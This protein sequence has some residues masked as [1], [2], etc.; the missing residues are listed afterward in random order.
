MEKQLWEMTLKQYREYQINSNDEETI[1]N[2][3]EL[4]KEDNRYYNDDWYYQ[5]WITVLENAAYD[6]HV[7]PEYVLRSLVNHHGKEIGE[8]VIHQ[9]FRGRASIGAEAWYK[10]QVNKQPR[11][12][13]IRGRPRK[14]NYKMNAALEHALYNR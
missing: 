8:Q 5:D 6:G 11:T 13:A 2:I 3:R 9:I 4:H 10:A 7:I 14:C 1:Q 12:M